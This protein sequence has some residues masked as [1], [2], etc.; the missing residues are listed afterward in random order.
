MYIQ[1]YAR[2]VSLF[3][4]FCCHSGA[5]STLCA[6]C[7]PAGRIV[8]YARSAVRVCPFTRSRPY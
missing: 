7:A 8:L 5:T 2:D 4:W 3:M 6:L 1:V